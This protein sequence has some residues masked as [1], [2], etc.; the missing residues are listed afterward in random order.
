MAGVK[1]ILHG[2]LAIQFPTLDAVSFSGADAE[3]GHRVPKKLHGFAVKEVGRLAA[4]F[5]I[6]FQFGGRHIL[7]LILVLIFS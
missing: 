4:R 2:P 3:I 6:V 5:D 7:F 1:T